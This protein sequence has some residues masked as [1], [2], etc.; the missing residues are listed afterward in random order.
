[1]ALSLSRAALYLRSTHVT[2]SLSPLW[3]VS[4]IVDWVFLSI[5]SYIHLKHSYYVID[6]SS[7]ESAANGKRE[8]RRHRIVLADDHE[9]FREWLKRTL[10]DRNDLEIVGEAA[11]GRTLLNMLNGGDLFPDMVIAD[12]SMPNLGGVQ[13]SREIKRLFPGMK[14]LIMTVHNEREYLEIALTSGAD[15]Y[16]LKDNADTDLFTAIEIIGKGG[17]FYPSRTNYTSARQVAKL[18]SDSHSIS[19]G[20][21]SNG[22]DEE[23]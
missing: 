12:I 14:V 2:P 22:T 5:D 9:K 3:V 15:G 13:L 20:G 6:T 10:A 16:I 21:S 11:D 8:N 17:M 18:Y 19:I 1:M 23:T 4:P 7:Q